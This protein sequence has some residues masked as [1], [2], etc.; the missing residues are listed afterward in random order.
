MFRYTVQGAIRR[1]YLLVGCWE[2]VLV[3]YYIQHHLQ[4]RNN[5]ACYVFSLQRE[6]NGDGIFTW[7]RCVGNYTSYNQCF[8]SLAERVF[9]VFSSVDPHTLC[10]KCIILNW[11][12]STDINYGTKIW[13][14]WK[15]LGTFHSLLFNIV[16]CFLSCVG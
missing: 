8:I 4:F 9:L 10:T 3:P 14:N 12:D 16:N 7:H 6:R 11:R 13:T 5:A 2:T 15:V 1:T